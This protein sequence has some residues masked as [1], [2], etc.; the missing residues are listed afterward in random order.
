MAA[1]PVPG[2]GI[3]RFRDFP[4]HLHPGPQGLFTN[5]SANAVD[6]VSARGMNHLLSSC[7][8]CGYVCPR[9]L[10]LL[11]GHILCEDCVL[12]ARSS[13]LGGSQT[14]ENGDSLDTGN[15]Q[16]VT[17]RLRVQCGM[18]AEQTIAHMRHIDP[19]VLES[20]RLFCHCGYQ[21]TLEQLSS[22]RWTCNVVREPLSTAK[23]DHSPVAAIDPQDI[24]KSIIEEAKRIYRTST[25]DST[26]QELESSLAQKVDQAVLTAQLHSL[27]VDLH[28][29][30]IEH[31]SCNELFWFNVKELIEE[32]DSM[33]KDIYSQTQSRL[34]AG[35]P[36]EVIIS[37]ETVETCKCFGVYVGPCS[38]P[39]S[40][41]WPMKKKIIL[42]IYDDN[43]Y[44]FGEFS[45]NTT[46][47]NS[48]KS[49]E[50]PESQGHISRWGKRGGMCPIGDLVRAM[51]YEKQNGMVCIGVEVKPF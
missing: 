9:H 45:F 19:F 40:A 48:R 50:K 39:H 14:T 22:H 41:E 18:C 31:R 15:E 32:H 21:G 25:T 49:F 37:V 30:V 20:V 43:G 7:Q 10:L 1:V 24:K 6:L 11:C 42:R 44:T 29:F 33:H 5:P 13:D 26:V 23:P 28:R 4:R 16:G 51:F 12:Y 8:K 17:K 35:Y 3:L 27:K 36:V 46:S 38:L 34:I 47:E 2:G